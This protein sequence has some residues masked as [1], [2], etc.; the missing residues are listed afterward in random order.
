MSSHLAKIFMLALC[1]FLEAA[2]AAVAQPTT[3]PGRIILQGCVMP[4]Q[5]PGC[6]T[7]TYNNRQYNVTSAVPPIKPGMVVPLAGT[8]TSE[9]TQCPG[10]N[11]TDI[12]YTPT[13]NFCM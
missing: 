11:L 8:I 12:T 4:T 7:I 2:A 1:L 3:G 5:P 10:I 6:L 9:P 13:N